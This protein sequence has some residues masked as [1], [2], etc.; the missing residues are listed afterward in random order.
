MVIRG[1]NMEERLEKALEFANY[2]QTLNNQLH[3]V[4]TRAEGLLLFAK[5]GGK[6]T[7]NKELICYFDYLNRSEIE[8]IAVLD[9]NNIPIL[10]ENVKEFLSEITQRNIEIT[11]DYLAEYQRIRKAR[12]VKSILDIS[13]V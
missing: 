6:F 10:I 5:N 8:Q 12:N 9:D 7:I 4:K 11:N 1:F 13:D 2:R 3:K